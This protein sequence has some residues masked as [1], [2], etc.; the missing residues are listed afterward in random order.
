MKE[1]YNEFAKAFERAE[2]YLYQFYCPKDIII[3]L[4]K[5]HTDKSNN[6]RLGWCRT[7]NHNFHIVTINSDG[8]KT[9]VTQARTELRIKAAYNLSRLIEAVKHESDYVKDEIENATKCILDS[10]SR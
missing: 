10:I 4:I 3:D 6:I 2:F 8:E 9:V 7:K 5:D 1:I